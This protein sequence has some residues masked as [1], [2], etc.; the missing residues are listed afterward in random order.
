M[1]LKYRY[2]KLISWLPP[3][4]NQWQLIFRGNIVGKGQ[5]H[6]CE[7]DR[8]GARIV[9]W[10]ILVLRWIF[11]Q[12]RPTIGDCPFRIFWDERTK[13]RRGSYFVK[14]SSRY[15]DDEDELSIPVQEVALKFKVRLETKSQ[16]RHRSHV[17]KLALYSSPYIQSTGSGN[18]VLHSYPPW[19]IAL[20]SMLAMMFPTYL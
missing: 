10:A 12:S 9:G 4:Q 7:R 20:S 11:Y 17:T 2:K 13:Q 1:N 3:W 5:D 16:F 14:N 8:P 15:F 6:I 18:M 19:S